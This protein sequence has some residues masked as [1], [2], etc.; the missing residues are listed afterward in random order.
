MSWNVGLGD[1]FRYPKLIRPLVHKVPY[2]P[3]QKKLKLIDVKSK[4]NIE[5]LGCFS[6]YENG[7]NTIQYHRSEVLKKIESLKDKVKVRSGFIDSNK[8]YTSLKDSKIVVCPF[9]YGEISWKDYEAFVNGACIFKPNMDFME[10]WPHYYKAEKTYVPFEW[11]LSDF[12]AKVDY[13]LSHSS[14]RLEIAH[15]AQVFFQETVSEAG[16]QAFCEHF[17][18]ILK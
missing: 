18:E 1:Y 5:L 10:T 2:F 11:D 17:K 13:Y 8:Y 3:S 6:L 7:A 9:G 4:R 15:Q 12:E 14:K 16:D